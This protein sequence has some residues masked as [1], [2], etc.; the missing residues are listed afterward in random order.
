M[1]ESGVQALGVYVQQVLGLLVSDAPPEVEPDFRGIGC[2]GY[3]VVHGKR[4]LGGLEPY[5]VNTTRNLTWKERE[6][7]YA[8]RNHLLMLVCLEQ[9]VKS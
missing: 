9:R 3:R 5:H 2:R 8:L 1:V 6:F 4:S 7:L